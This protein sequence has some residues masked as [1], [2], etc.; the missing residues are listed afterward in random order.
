MALDQLDGQTRLSNT[1]ATDHDQLVFSKK[2]EQV[3]GCANA[4]GGG[5]ARGQRT[6]DAIVKEEE[7]MPDDAEDAGQ[8]VY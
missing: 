5:G 4:K 7:E 3:S 6:L 2:L 1:T 8:W